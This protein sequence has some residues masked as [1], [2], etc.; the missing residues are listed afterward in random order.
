MLR[1]IAPAAL[2]IL[3]VL[4]LPSG[5]PAQEWNPPSRTMPSMPTADQL[6]SDWRAAVRPWF[7][8][9]EAASGMEIAGLRAQPE[10]R[11]AQGQAKFVRFMSGPYPVAVWSDRNSDGRADLIEIYRRGVL[12]YQVID[13][14][15]DGAANVLRVH[16]A[17]GRLLREERLR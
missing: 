6:R 11:S 15:Y 1:F 2:A 5:A 17:S 7:D 14:D 8:G 13:A 12:A 16:D 10:G 9:V 4:A 3:A